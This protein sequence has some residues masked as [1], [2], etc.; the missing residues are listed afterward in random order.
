M[1][2]PPAEHNYTKKFLNLIAAGKLPRKAGLNHCFIYHDD[3]CSL[4][5]G[6]GLCDCDPDI[7]LKAHPR[8]QEDN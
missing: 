3:C 6:K 4:L 5:H 8:P 2:K 1:D 7:V